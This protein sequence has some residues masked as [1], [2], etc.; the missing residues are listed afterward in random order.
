MANIIRSLRK[1]WRMNSMRRELARLSDGQ[2][3]DI[4]IHRGQI[5]DLARYCHGIGPR[6]DSI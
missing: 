1:G 5:D 4:G 6:P 2:L 3:R